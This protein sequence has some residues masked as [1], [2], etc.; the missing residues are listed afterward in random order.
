M[1]QHAR[2]NRQQQIG[3]EIGDLQPGAVGLADA[4][5]LLKMF[6]EDVE[7]PIGQPPD[8]EAGDGEGQ[9]PAQVA[10]RAKT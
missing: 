8:Q 4:Q 5:R 10:S 7:Q 1:Q 6:I 2:R 9:R 3:P